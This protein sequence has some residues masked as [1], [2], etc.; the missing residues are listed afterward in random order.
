MA[1]YAITINDR[2]RGKNIVI[3]TEGFI[4]SYLD[5]KGVG[6][7]HASYK[8]VDTALLL[9]SVNEMCMDAFKAHPELRETVNAVMK[10]R[11][12]KIFLDF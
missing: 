6:G 10:H 2:K 12:K 7:L 5:E 8:P 1:R 4:L 3:D 11:G 9:T